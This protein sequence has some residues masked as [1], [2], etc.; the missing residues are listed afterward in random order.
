MIDKQHICLITGGAIGDIP[1]IRQAK[2]LGF[3]VITSGNRPQDLGHTYADEYIAADY[4]SS[5][6]IQQICE[7]RS[8]DYLVS[9]CHDLAYIAASIVAKNLGYPGFDT[10]EIAETLHSKN[11]LRQA[12]KNIGVMTPQFADCKNL[13]EGLSAIE[14]LQFPVIVK[15]VDLTGGN[16]I[17]LCG[18]KSYFERAFL[19]AFS[20]SRQNRVIVEEFL[21][22]T[23]HGF[24]GLVVR[25]K[26]AS[27]FI[28]DEYYV[29]N[30]FRV[31]ATSFPSS[32]GLP[33][34]EI[35]T[36]D[37]NTIVRSLSLTDGL[38]HVQFLN[39]SS[40]PIIIEIM[41]RTPG[42]LYPS[43]VQLATGMNYAHS[44]LKPYLEDSYTENDLIPL[45]FQNKSQEITLRYML[46]AK[47]RGVI[48]EFKIDKNISLKSSFLTRK[49]G[50]FI[51]H[52]R[53]DTCA[54]LFYVSSKSDQNAALLYSQISSNSI[55]RISTSN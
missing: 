5:W 12:L 16:G 55:V 45:N 28:D 10:P 18:D 36:E 3:W 50:D 21:Q 20:L 42:D 23:Y 40:R 51:E 27:F 22:G 24:S 13:D 31:S 35:L 4:T 38:L 43:F 8:V 52:P 54:I 26:V 17:T 49:I 39:T 15:P 33:Q 1:I 48:K 53:I 25:G 6:E 30:T 11:L 46:M 34:I 32:I 41:R 2:A 7:S 44:I 14:T 9:S 19:K 29:P 47:S 37:L